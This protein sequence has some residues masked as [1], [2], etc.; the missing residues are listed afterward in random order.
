MTEQPTQHPPSPDRCSDQRAA[1]QTLLDLVSQ[2]P[3][4]P[5]AFVS[6]YVTSLNLQLDS[7]S[8]FEA[9]REVLEAPASEVRLH[10]TQSSV[11]LTVDTTADGV[12]VHLSGFNVPVSYVQAQAPRDRSAVAA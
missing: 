7:P 12:P 11:W 3:T 5:A 4:L 10:A 8:D 9:W 2:Y 1:V 6:V